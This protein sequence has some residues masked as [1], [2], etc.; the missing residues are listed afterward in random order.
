MANQ[1]SVRHI[2]APTLSG[3]HP[4]DGI[5]ISQLAGPALTAS[6]DTLVRDIKRHIGEDQPLEAVVVVVDERPIGLVMSLRMDRMLS[7]RF[8]VSLFYDRPV[9]KIMDPDPL[10][11]EAGHPLENVARLAMNRERVRAYD[12]VIVVEQGLF[13]GTVSVRRILQSMADLNQRRS[14]QLTRTNRRLKREMETRARAVD[15][16]KDSRE[17]LQLVID[18]MPI[19]V[20]WKDSESVYMGCNRLFAS[21]AGLKRPE[22]VFGK[23]DA[24]LAWKPEEASFFRDCDCRVMKNNRPEYHIIESQRQADGRQAF[25]DTNKV[26]LHNKQGKVVGILGTYEDITERLQ[27]DQERAQLKK[28]LSRAEK[29]EA[30]GT[31]AG[32]VAHDLNNI[33]SGIVSYPELLLLDLP[34]ESRL[35]EPILTIKESGERAAAIVQDLL[36]LT[37][38]GVAATETLNLNETIWNYLESPE[39]RN[40]L[41]YHPAVHVELDLQE[42]LL[43]MSGSPVHL[44]KTLMNLV[45]NASEAMPDGGRILIQTENRY[46][47]H[48]LRGYDEIQ[49]G[50]YVVLSVCDNGVGIAEDDL[51]RIFE[52]F[53]TRKVMGRSGT[54]LGMAV[55]WGTVKDHQGYIDVESKVGFGTAFTLFFPVMRAFSRRPDEHTDD[56]DFSGK[57]ELILVIDDMEAQRT[58]ASLMLQ[59]LGYRVDAVSSGEE[60]CRYLKRQA[61]DLL[62]LD[63]IMDPGMDGLET[64]RRI[65]SFRPNQ[66]A[67]IASGFSETKRVRK[68]QRLGA[69]VYVKKPYTLENL[70]RA[71]RETLDRPFPRNSPRQ[72]L[73]AR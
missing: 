14:E 25:L 47:D 16:L 46:L 21:N 22:E 33:L 9:S 10:I 18:S 58:I 72:T 30:I 4:T 31:V 60:A 29:M 26:P 12:D 8:G 5:R 41:S 24:D 20:F 49:K 6:P 51:S 1:A 45:S 56:A 42:D 68:A 19:A 32:G 13:R 34:K 11:V 17:M 40:L 61:V 66:R 69:A 59:R 70:G 54:G 71:V 15:A 57:G 23:T 28:Q 73:K 27:H 7:Q 39:H 65:L 36:T 53:Y 48:P 43:P 2:D 55:V 52:P 63:M 35:R 3:N 62:V 38:R 44:A 50:D 67:M 64:Y 37:R